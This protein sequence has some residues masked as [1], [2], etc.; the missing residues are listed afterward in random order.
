MK[1]IIICNKNVYLVCNICFLAF[2][3]SKPSGSYIVQRRLFGK[4]GQLAARV[5]IRNLNIYRTLK[6]MLVLADRDR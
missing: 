3:C 1:K 2:C 4:S 6:F 5:L